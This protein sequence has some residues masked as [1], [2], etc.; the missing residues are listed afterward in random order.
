MK[1]Q[2]TATTAF[3]PAA[4][5]AASISLA[6]VLLPGSAVPAHSSGL[7]PA[8]RAVAGNVVA[9]VEAPAGTVA[10]G[11]R[12]R[13][14]VA[15]H[16]ARTTPASTS[17]HATAVATPTTPAQRRQTAHRRVRRARPATR[18]HP[19]TQAASPVTTSPA[20]GHG[21]G[22]AK[23]LGHL[24]KAAPEAAH[25]AVPASRG[26]GSG[27]GKALGHSADAPHG[28]PAVPPGQ[29]KKAV[30]GAGG[31]GASHGPGGTR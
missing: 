9:A 2:A 4:L 27:H 29:A 21:R 1:L 18:V 26:A 3:L 7:A 16:A 28:P 12:H 17:S 5:A 14:P 22:K 19:T 10:K 15:R 13:K 20:V 24:K 8:L 23:A 11:H 6:L 31:H 30:P 25:P